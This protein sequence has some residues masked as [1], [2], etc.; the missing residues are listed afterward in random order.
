MHGNS[1]L[2]LS[3]ETKWRDRIL[4]EYYWEDA[5]PQTPTQ[6]AV[7]TDQY[8]FIRSQGVW[9]I[10]QLFDIQKDPFELNNLIRSP[11][12]QQIAKQLNQE[13]W[14]WLA[15]TNRL[16]ISLKPIKTLQID[17]LYKGTW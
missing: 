3:K 14:D 13:L 2:P 17:N 5:F 4:Y 7:R 10:D 11:E 9:D 12:Y 15:K 8:K 1:F 6:Y 16:Q